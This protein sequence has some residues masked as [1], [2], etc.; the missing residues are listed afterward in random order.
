MRTVKKPKTMG[1][2]K[3]AQKDVGFYKY[4]KSNK[5]LTEKEIVT[6]PKDTISLFWKQYTKQEK[7][8]NIPF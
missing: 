2:M 7:E 6:L 5:G 3:V 1:V 8:D 4:I